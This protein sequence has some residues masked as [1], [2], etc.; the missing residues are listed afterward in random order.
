MDFTPEAWTDRVARSL[1]FDV[2]SWR[3]FRRRLRPPG[4]PA[5]PVDVYFDVYFAVYFVGVCRICQL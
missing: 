1:T 5:P 4:P 2:L 3:I